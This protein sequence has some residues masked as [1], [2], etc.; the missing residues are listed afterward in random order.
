MARRVNDLWNVVEPKGANL[1]ALRELQKK[2][3]A[4]QKSKI[5]TGGRCANSVNGR[6]FAPPLLGFTHIR[7]IAVL[8]LTDIWR[9]NC[10]ALAPTIF[11]GARLITVPTTL[12]I[13]VR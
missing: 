8:T 2:A 6:P 1:K 5:K 9:Y 7:Q 3:K 11:T 10:L 4:K 13:I 12:A